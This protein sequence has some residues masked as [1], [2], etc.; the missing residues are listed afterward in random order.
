MN[1]NTYHKK[2]QET[3]EVK[4][5]ILDR[6]SFSGHVTKLILCFLKKPVDSLAA[7]LGHACERIYIYSSF[8]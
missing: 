6:I 5:K 8:K 1:V 3:S 2:P 7:V 4:F